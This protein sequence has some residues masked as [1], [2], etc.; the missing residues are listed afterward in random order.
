M[1]NTL[2]SVL[3]LA[4][5]AASGAADFAA[6]AEKAANYVSG[7]DVVPLR[8]LERALVATI[9]APADRAQAEAALVRMLAADA[10]F[11]AK[12]FAC[13]RLSEYGTDAAVPALA[14]LLGAEETAGLACIALGGIRT[15]KAAEALRTALAA[16]KGPSRVQG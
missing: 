16:S 13:E 8:E 11:E 5:A 3:V 6:L 12:R 7:G 15:E 9:D 4:V 10:S 2:T 14:A 1:K